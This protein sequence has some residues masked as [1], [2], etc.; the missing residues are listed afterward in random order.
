MAW[1]PVGIV[2][3]LPVSQ[4]KKVVVAGEDIAIYHL[5]EGFFATSDICT[6]ADESLTKGSFCDHIVTCPK[7]GG[8]FDIVSGKAVHFP[9]VTAVD[10]YA[11]EQ[12]D[13]VLFIN[14]E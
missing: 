2:S 3:D 13:G 11:V 6:H 5:E 9:C 1:I 10:T 12:R 7:H 8:Q 14:M 4:M